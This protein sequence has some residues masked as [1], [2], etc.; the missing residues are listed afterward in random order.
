MHTFKEVVLNAYYF[1][2]NVLKSAKVYRIRSPS[3]LEN[4]TITVNW[5]EMKRYWAVSDE[6]F[7][8]IAN[9]IHSEAEPNR[10]TLL[11]WFWETRVNF[12]FF[13][14]CTFNQ[15][16][17]FLCVLECSTIWRITSHFWREW[18]IL[19]CHW[20][21]FTLA[22]PSASIL[23]SSLLRTT[24]MILLESICVGCRKRKAT[25]LWFSSLSYI[26]DALLDPM[27]LNK[28]L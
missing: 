13:N 28:F 17:R 3:H 26:A 8:C 4:G 25:S 21:N 27:H 18:L 20:S 16:I 15:L 24:V 14:L 6:E 1:A 19:L 9:V 23:D 2:L 12:P 22:T 11:N 7:I 10:I 5:K